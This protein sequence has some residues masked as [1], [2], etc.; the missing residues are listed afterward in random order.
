M[1]DR[2]LT[3]TRPAP[4]LPAWADDER[5]A[6]PG[7]LHRIPAEIYPGTPGA[8]VAWQLGQA[9]L[10]WREAHGLTQRQL[11]A[12]LGWSQS[13]LARLEGGGV[14]P[15]LTTLATLVTTLS[16]RVTVT[17]GKDVPTVTLTKSTAATDAA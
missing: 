4:P 6:R 5:P 1:P 15:T 10:A 2:D 17:P 7:E 8:S 12:R 14:A 13:T 9:V 11:A 16:V 3:T